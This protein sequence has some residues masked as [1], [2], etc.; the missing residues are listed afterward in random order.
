M[1]TTSDISRGLIIKLDGSLY[2][3]VE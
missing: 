3:V 2:S 1:A